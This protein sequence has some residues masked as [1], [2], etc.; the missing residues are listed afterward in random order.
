MII[1]KS[2][3]KIILVL[4]VLLLIGFAGIIVYAVI[5]DYKPEEKEI[6]TVSNK[7]D[8]LPDTARITLLTWNIGYCGLDKK[9]DFFY[10]GGTKVITPKI[11]FMQNINAVKGF[12]K[13]NDSIDFILIQEIDENSRRSYHFN[14]YDTVSKSLKGFF[15][16]FAK[17]YDVFFVPVP[18]SNPMGKVLSGLGTFS[19]Y[20]PS[21]S[22]RYSFPGEYGFPKQLF[23]LDRCFMVNRYPLANGKELLIINTH[24]EA[25]DPG[26]IRK[27]QMAYLREFLL[28]EY[29]KGNYIISGG[30]WNQ[31]PPDFRPEFAANKVNTDQMMINTDFLPH[32]WKWVYDNKTPSNRT[33]I[34][35]YNPSTTAT[36]VI[37]L[38]LL[39][40]NVKVESVR[41]INL[42]FEN[43]DHNPV[44][45]KVKL[46]K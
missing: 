14:E 16:F 30:D 31:S 23:M 18:P 17:N 13:Q 22:I 38:F 42:E 28:F 40:P 43:S 15:P 34:S 44:R 12:L 41:C 36:T 1:L 5:S 33:V 39:S 19:K 4:V 21:S 20:Q 3:L 27:A 25:F 11:N 32:E 10:D 35:A 26:E 24:N 2:I 9:M 7:P 45:V 8:I 46:K 37:D 29:G 6:I